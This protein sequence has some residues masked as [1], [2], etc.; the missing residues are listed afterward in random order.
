MC[1]QQGSLDDVAA[2]W[3]KFM[4]RDLEATSSSEVLNKDP[5]TGSMGDFSEWSDACETG[6]DIT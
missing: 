1:F 3:I 5:G 4:C 2:S 6:N